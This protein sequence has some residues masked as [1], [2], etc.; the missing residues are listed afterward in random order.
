MADFFRLA[1]P[2]KRTKTLVLPALIL[3]MLAQAWD[4]HPFGPTFLL[5]FTAI[6]FVSVLSLS[7][8]RR[9][10]A[11]IAQHPHPLRAIYAILIASFLVYGAGRALMHIA[12]RLSA[13][14]D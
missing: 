5:A 8:Q 12:H 10:A 14:P 4:Y 7:G 6:V 2:R 3:G 9:P 13:F 11:W 1:R